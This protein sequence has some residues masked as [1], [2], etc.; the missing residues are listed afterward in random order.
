MIKN[1]TSIARKRRNNQYQY[2]DSPPKSGES[3]HPHTDKLASP[4]RAK[5]RNRNCN[6]NFR[7]AAFIVFIF[8]LCC[9]CC[10][11]WL[12]QRSLILVSPP[13]R[14]VVTPSLALAS[15]CKCVN[16]DEDEV[17]GGLWRGVKYPPRTTPSP[18]SIARNSSSNSSSGGDS[19]MRAKQIHIVISHCTKGL[20]SL[21]NYTTGI[22]NGNNGGVEVGIYNNMNISIKSVH[23]ISKCGVAVEG[24]PESLKAIT[25]I[26]VLPNVGRCDHSYA[27]YINTILDKHVPVPPPKSESQKSEEQNSVVLFLKDDMSNGNIHQGPHVRNSWNDMESMVRVATSS[28]GFACGTVIKPDATVGRSSYHKTD[29]LM[30]FAMKRYKRTGQGTANETTMFESNFANLQSFVDKL[31]IGPLPKVVQVCYGGV[32]AASVSS[33][34]K[35]KASVWKTSENILS[36]GDNI[37]EGHYMERTWGMLLAAPLET[38]QMDALV[39]CSTVREEKSHFKGMLRKVPKSKSCDYPP[40]SLLWWWWMDWMDW[41][42]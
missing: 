7:K 28:N 37:Q 6:Y 19:D 12:Q 20:H 5:K 40:P 10:S 15:S 4:F 9:S 39:K 23:I 32:F 3:K 25:T 29:G 1:Q 11:L 30:T 36:R 17:C 13:S 26:E 42:V 41:L 24:I 22:S 21:A 16:C 14:S 31:D 2:K 27:H 34:R 33:I 8:V 35:T 38:Y 18:R